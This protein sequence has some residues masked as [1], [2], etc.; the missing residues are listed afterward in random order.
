[1]EAMP[2]R[3]WVRG[4]LLW[5]AVAAGAC[6]SG[7]TGPSTPTPTSTPTPVPV[8]TCTAGAPQPMTS[9]TADPATITDGDTFTLSWA[10]PCGFVSL[11][12]KGKGP[13]QT[14]LPSTGSY[15]LR[16]GLD[17]YPTASGNTVL[18]ARNADTA[19]PR[20]ATVTVTAKATPTISLAGASSCYPVKA[21]NA[22]CNVPVTATATNYS[23]IAWSGC[24]AGSSGTTGTCHVPD[25]NAYTCTASATGAGGSAQADKQ[26]TGTNAAPIVASSTHN[27]GSAGCDTDVEFD[28]QITDEEGIYDC[29]SYSATPCT[30]TNIQCGP[31][32]GDP[33]LVKIVVHT[34]TAHYGG[35]MCYVSF[36]ARDVWLASSPQGNGSCG[37]YACP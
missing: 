36:V 14:L 25:L 37:L 7:P 16:P 31:T 11:A 4:V 32:S 18:E 22:G 1:M 27:P 33:K 5:T 26:V 29:A 23:S 30:I 12:Q 21:G 13:F 35:G 17:G 10:A 34:P 3:V 24:C 28:F 15:V 19:T 6:S 20:E 2:G 9:F 8:T